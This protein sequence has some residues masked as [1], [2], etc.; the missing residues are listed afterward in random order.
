M[1]CA[2]GT[3]RLEDK[4]DFLGEP[5]A[6]AGAAQSVEVRESHMSFV[7]LAGGLAYKL[8]KPVRFS[9]LDFST[10]ERRAAACLAEH[11][12]N[13]RLAPN[14]YLS[15]EPLT[16]SPS[17]LAIGGGGAVVDWLVVMRRLDAEASLEA[18]LLAHRLV[19][20]DADR[21]A[22]TLKEFY[23]RG[24]RVGVPAERHVADWRHALD[25]NRSILCNP[26]FS[27]PAGRI[28]RIA[29]VL[30][31]FLAVDAGLLEERVRRGRIIDAH[32]DLR[33]EHVFL[34]EPVT[35][36]DCLEFDWKLR[37]VDPLDEVAFLH[38]ECERLGAA[39]AGERIRRRLSTLLGEDRSSGLFLFYR[40]QRA[41]LR[42]RLSIAHLLDAAPRTPEKWPRQ[43]RAYLEL[44]ATDATRLEGLLKRREGPSRAVLHAAGGSPRRIAA[45]R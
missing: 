2:S 27:L 44:A 43:A 23:R 6:Y 28:A 45:R 21:V 3:I 37:A 24:R 5:A 41:M 16:V 9:Y 25:Y 13:R 22:A 38:L 36:I 1:T 40:I 31:D 19:P 11:R 35:I 34:T 7:F 15:V 33:P 8:K 12:L 32:G 10:P 39:W 42:A 20:L 29:A 18:A 17:G 30:R 14:V 26:R 4:V